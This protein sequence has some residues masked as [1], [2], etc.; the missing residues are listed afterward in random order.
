MSISEAYNLV[1]DSI[2][3]IDAERKMGASAGDISS[4]Q[5][6]KSITA[7]TAAINVGLQ[8]GGAS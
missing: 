1:Y 3:V 6:R 8:R 4:E 7:Q 2:Q 5:V